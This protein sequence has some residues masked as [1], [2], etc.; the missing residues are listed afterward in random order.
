LDSLLDSL[1]VASS[2]TTTAVTAKM[3]SI[4]I[5]IEP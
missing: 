4:N 5:T 1:A 3:I 2:V